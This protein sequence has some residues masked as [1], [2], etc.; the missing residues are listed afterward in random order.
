MKT[1]FKLR[2]GNSTPFKMM[3][4]SSPLQK[5]PKNVVKAVRKAWDYAKKYFSKVKKTKVNNNTSTTRTNAGGN[6]TTTTTPTSEITRTSWPNV[7]PGTKSKFPGTTTDAS[8]NVTAFDP[9]KRQ[10]IQ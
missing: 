1:P 3:G 10:V 6:S 9:T 7:K 8:G 2:S 5:N 4:S